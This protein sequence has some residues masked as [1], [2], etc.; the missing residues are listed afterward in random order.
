MS[1]H[2]PNTDV[3]A[4]IEDIDLTNRRSILKWM[5][6]YFVYRTTNISTIAGRQIRGD[7]FYV[8]AVALPSSSIAHKLPHI[9]LPI[10][11]HLMNK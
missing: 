2:D 10:I 5:Q 3:H 1:A 7:E 4:H 9:P 6:K 11:P 8:N